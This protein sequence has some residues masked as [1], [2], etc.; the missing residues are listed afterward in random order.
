LFGFLALLGPLSA[1]L[2]AQDTDVF[3]VNFGDAPVQMDPA[4]G[5]T[6]LEAQV[7][8]ALYEGL[9]V[10][11]PLSLRAQPG[12]AQ[13][14][15]TSDDGLTLTFTLR[16]GLAFEDGTPLTAGVFRQSYLRL[17]DPRTAAPYASLLDAVVGAQARRE[18]KAADP[19]AVGLEA[20]DDRTLVFHLN[21]P[22]PELLSVLCHYAFVPLH[23]AW[24]ASPTAQPAPANGPY[25]FRSQE[26]GHWVL[27]KNPRY[28]DA[29]HV[30]F[31][32]L[33]FT[34]NDDAVNVTRAYK[35]GKI[36][37]VAGGIDMNT[38]MGSRY[39]NSNPMF[40]TSFLYFKAAQAPWTDPRVRKA[41]VLLLPL[42]E[43]RQVYL[44]PTTVLIPPFQGY[45][46]V[47]GLAKTDH[48][49]ALALLAD[50]GF[51]LGK[52]LPPL[53]TAFPDDPTNERFL[54]TF[55][56]AWAELGLEVRNTVVKGSYYDQIGGLA[57]Q[58]GYYNWIGDFLDPVTF[59]ELWKGG[60]SLNSFS[61]ADPA[62][63]ALLTKAATQKGDERLKT[64]AEAEIGLLQGALLVPLGHTPSLNLIDREEIG[65]WYQ[66]PLDIHPFK[67]LYRKD[68]PHLKN[69]VRF[70]LS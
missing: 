70:D 60:G 13:S 66:N 48:D 20:P 39:V 59:L 51:P 1:P 47:E 15:V 53:V 9:V 12:A 45:P 24:L 8:P 19:G 50:A 27:E 10:Y 55:R 44:Q 49:Q 42:E 64:L 3:R 4:K 25:R 32:V 30:A 52:G 37:W 2:A 38:N 18:G 36:D 41:L 61:Y 29:A 11:D 26:A 16:P 28:W 7:L 58:I 54:E 43:L 65:G 56:K 21:Q 46:K 35:E 23:P 62:Y 22:A 57:H 17:L 63:D 6:V 40:G 68:P 5:Q 33:D 67:N 14:W 69:L 34:F 31:P